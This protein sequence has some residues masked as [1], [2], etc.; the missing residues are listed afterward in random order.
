MLHEIKSSSRPQHSAH[1]PQ[2]LRLTLHGAQHQG[3]DHHIHGAT[4]HWVHILSGSHQEALKLQVTVLRKALDQELLKVGVGV[5]T[6]HPASRRIE[7]EVGAGATAHLQQGELSGGALELV[8][9]AEELPLLACHLFIVR[10]TESH[11]EVG[12]AF[13]TYPAPQAQKVQQVHGKCQDVDHQLE[14]KDGERH[15]PENEKTD[16]SGDLTLS[17]KSRRQASGHTPGPISFAELGVLEWKA[18]TELSRGQEG[19]FTPLTD[20]WQHIDS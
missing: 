5:N 4:G 1:L 3:A 8:Q 6:G 16:Q 9:V 12:E 20:F 18:A 13:F 14:D 10:L 11:Q 7:L 19:R 2:H 15:Y 17:F